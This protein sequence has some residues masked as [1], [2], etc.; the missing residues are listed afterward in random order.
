MLQIGICDDIMEA[1]MNLNIMLE[2]LLEQRGISFQIF[3]FSSGEGLL[4]WMNKHR[5]E[6]D[7]VFLDIEMGKL[8]GM[9]TAK[10]L[11]SADESLQ[12][13]FVTGFTD[14]VFEGY[15]V[16]ALGYLLKPPKHQQLEDVMNRALASLQ[17]QEEELFFCRAGESH[18]RIRKDAILYFTSELRQVTCV[19]QVRSYTFYG[20]LDEVAEQVGTGFVRIHQRYLVRAAAVSRVGSGE[21]SVGDDILPISR[22]CQQSALLALTR[23]VLE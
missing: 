23:A 15:G 1:R 9:E 19:T 16:G 14:Y 17:R 5:G 18:Y 4:S 7:L 11:R 10:R 3:E 22:S 21:L 13:V 8:N 6:L 12:L 20:K 2:K